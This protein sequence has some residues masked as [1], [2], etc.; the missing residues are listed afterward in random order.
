MTEK[1]GTEII[2]INFSSDQQDFAIMSTAKTPIIGYRQPQSQ[3]FG[4]QNEKPKSF[5]FDDEIQYQNNLIPVPL[6]PSFGQ[7]AQVQ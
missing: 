3:S 7:P 1:S 2:N 5:G 6:A 4:Y